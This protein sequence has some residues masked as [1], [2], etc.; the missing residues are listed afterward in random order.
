MAKQYWNRIREA[1]LIDFANIIYYSLVLLQRRPEILSYVSSKFAWL[2]VDEFQ[3]TTDLQ[4]EILSLIAQSGRTCFLLVGDPFQSIFRFAG[5]R[6]DLAD[7]FAVRIGART[8]LGLSGNF[9]SSPP[10]LRHAELLYRRTPAMRAV[11][12]ARIFTEVPSWQHGSSTFEVIADHFLPA[13]E[14]LEIDVGDAA[15]LA[16]AWFTLFPLGQRLREY[17]VSIVGPGARPYRRNRQFAPLAEHVCG[18]LTEPDPAAIQG[19]ERTLFN[20]LLDVTGRVHFDIFSYDGRVV[21]FRLLA[22]AKQLHQVHGRNCLAR[23][24]GTSL[25]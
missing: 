12:T 13:L 19:I 4:V 7:K 5:A 23:S 3:D 21:V 9:R 18:Y 20:T 1:G 10:I 24:R 25:F 22:N 17:G 15:I 14:G 16:P 2:L 6:P 11:G 8:D